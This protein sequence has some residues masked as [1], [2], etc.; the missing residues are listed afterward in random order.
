MILI[1][2]IVVGLVATLIRAKINHRPLKLR[3][4]SWE[5]LVF[6]AVIPQI[7]VFQIPAISRFVPETFVPFIQITSMLGL[8]V[9][10]A[11]NFLVP[12]F[13]ALGFGLLS[14]FLVILMNGG[15]MPVSLQTLSRLTSSKPETYWQIGTRLG[16][17]KD[18]IMAVEDTKLVWLSD[19]LTLPQWF[20]YKFAFSV[21]D[22]L[23]SIGT[24]ILLWSLSNK[25]GD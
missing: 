6:V 15:W 21:G 13:W 17:S 20:P 19:V 16:Y 22:V 5:W 24:L 1:F 9:F 7:L 18:Y 14:N 23:I 12:G 25:N 3:K 11:R 10:V 2:A 4:L 8:L